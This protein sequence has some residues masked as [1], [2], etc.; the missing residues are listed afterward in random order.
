M[1]YLCLVLRVAFRHSLDIAQ[2]II[3]LLLIGLGAVAHFYP[4]V[5]SMIDVSGWAV[6]AIVLG[7]IVLIRLLMAPYWIWKEDQRRL[8]DVGI[9]YGLHVAGFMPALDLGN[10][11]NA[12]EIR[13]QLQNTTDKPLSYQVMELAFTAGGHK[14]VSSGNPT[15]IPA[16][17]SPTFFANAGLPKKIYQALP[18]RAMG[19]VTLKIRYGIAGQGFSRLCERS[20]RIDIFKK[21]AGKEL[22]INWTQIAEKDDAI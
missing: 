7:G 12:L 15:V 21:S 11:T 13:P 3:F 14:A 10:V 5:N 22:H 4:A 16:K 2:T 9:A 17:G 8:S 18:A 1:G 20:F 6:A 19:E